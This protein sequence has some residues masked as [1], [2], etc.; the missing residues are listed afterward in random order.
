MNNNLLITKIKSNNWTTYRLAKQ[1]NLEQN[2]IEKVVNGKVKDPRISTVVKI[3]KAL[4][5]SEHEF[6]RLCGY[7]DDKND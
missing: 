7:I 5:L 4:E 2:R 1:M 3:A 6:A